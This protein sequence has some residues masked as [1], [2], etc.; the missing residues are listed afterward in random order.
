MGKL[1]GINESTVRFI[2]KNEAKIKTALAATAPPSA[3]QVSHIRNS[4]MSQMESALFVWITDQN[5]KDNPI[6]SNAIRA[7]GKSLY[8]RLTSAETS[9]SDEA[10]PPAIL[11][12]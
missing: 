8:E 1:S 6:D 4:A 2:K 5:K 3:K 10:L 7:K 12:S 11:N 9:T